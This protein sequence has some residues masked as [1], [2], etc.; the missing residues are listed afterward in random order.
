MQEKIKE[1]FDINNFN[2]Y[3]DDNYYY[4]FRALNMADNDDLDKKIIADEI[5]NISRIRTNL[6]RYQNDP[7]YSSDAEISLEEMCDHI[8]MHQSLMLQ[9]NI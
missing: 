1:L 6:E 2:I 3:S 9:P 5:G 8:K 7:K 4:F